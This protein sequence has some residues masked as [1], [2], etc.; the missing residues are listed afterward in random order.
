MFDDDHGHDDSNATDSR[1][2]TG[3]A[4]V[5]NTFLKGSR[6]VAQAANRAQASVLGMSC[7]TLHWP[8]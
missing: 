8:L 6:C 7:N 5:C 1:Q 4:E 2:N 3:S